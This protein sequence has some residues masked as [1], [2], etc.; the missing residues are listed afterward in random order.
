MPNWETTLVQHY[1]QYKNKLHSNYKNILVNLWQTE[2]FFCPCACRLCFWGHSGDDYKQELVRVI[3]SRTTGFWEE[4]S[5]DYR[6]RGFIASCQ[7]NCGE[8]RSGRGGFHASK[9]RCVEQDKGVVVPAADASSER[10]THKDDDAFPVQSVKTWR[11]LL[12]HRQ[13]LLRLALSSPHGPSQD[14][15]RQK[16]SRGFLDPSLLEKELRPKEL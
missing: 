10:P 5:G 8:P 4:R 6:F 13:L 9:N 2:L 11:S 3:V 16:P 1:K 7:G 15:T 14:F 12:S